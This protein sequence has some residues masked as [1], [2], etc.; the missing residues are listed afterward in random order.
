MIAS[1]HRTGS[2]DAEL[3]VPPFRGLP[4]L[5]RRILEFERAWWRV[6]AV[7]EDAIR[8]QFD[9]STTRYYQ[10]LNNLID[11]PEA[12]CADPVLVRRLRRLRASRNEARTSLHRRT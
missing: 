8:E 4:D 9:F 1:A 11:N 12:L 3:G 2:A 7:K 5:D 6:G 10:T